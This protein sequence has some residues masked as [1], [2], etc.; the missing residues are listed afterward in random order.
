MSV[1][2]GIR[3]LKHVARHSGVRGNEVCDKLDVTPLK[4]FVLL[5]Y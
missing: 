4:C 3:V 2:A 1:V 5:V